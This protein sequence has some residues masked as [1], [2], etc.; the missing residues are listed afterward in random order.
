MIYCLIS[1]IIIA[2]VALIIVIILE[3]VIGAFFQ[4]SSQV[5]MLIRLLVGLLVLLYALNCLLPFLS[6]GGH[7]AVR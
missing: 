3:Q 4:L 6:G 5:F 7:W 1:L 2:I